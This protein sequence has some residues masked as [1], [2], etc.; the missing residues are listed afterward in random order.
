[1]ML[2]ILQIY[3]API[4]ILVSH[5]RMLQAMDFMQTYSSRLHSGNQLIY[6]GAGNGTH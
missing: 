2:D 4:Y 3:G 1:M 5:C 6:V